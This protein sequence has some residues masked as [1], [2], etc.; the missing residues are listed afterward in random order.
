MAA[1]FGV[2]VGRAS[3]PRAIGPWL[4]TVAP[5]C[6]DGISRWDEATRY[7]GIGCRQPPHRSSC[8]FRSRRPTT[9]RVLEARL[10]MRRI[11]RS[12]PD[13]VIR[14]SSPQQRKG[15]SR[16]AP[17]PDGIH[18]PSSSRSPIPRQRRS[19]SCRWRPPT[20]S[21]SSILNCP[22]WRRS[23]SSRRYRSR[24]PPSS[25]LRWSMAATASGTSAAARSISAS[26]PSGMSS[27]CSCFRRSGS[28]RRQLSRASPRSAP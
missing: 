24:R 3:M 13:Q 16:C 6:A 25:R 11:T 20:V 15:S 12:G 2:T 4:R 10:W 9:R 7:R 26:T 22:V 19:S 27:P 17:W 14:I 5:A 8:S 18:S 1:P 28:L 21:A 23:S